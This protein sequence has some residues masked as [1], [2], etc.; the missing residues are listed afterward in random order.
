VAVPQAMEAAV[1]QAMEAV[2]VP[3][4]MVAV[5]QPSTVKPPQHARPRP[6]WI[7]EQTNH[8]NQEH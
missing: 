8:A 3:Q 4:A 6:P 7:P 2:A 5:A 1:P